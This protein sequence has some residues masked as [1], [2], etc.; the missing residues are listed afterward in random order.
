[1]S[2]TKAELLQDLLDADDVIRRQFAAIN[3]MKDVI[4]NL[5][6]DLRLANRHHEAAK[7]Q[8][9]RANE[10]VEKIPGWILWLLRV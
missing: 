7:E 6:N 8:A 5:R 10:T 3:E 2:K 4:A 9:N 1:M